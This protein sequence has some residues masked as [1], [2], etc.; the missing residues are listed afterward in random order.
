MRNHRFT[1]ATPEVIY[2]SAYQPDAASAYPVSRRAR[3]G[4]QLP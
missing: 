2:A 1:V 4:D 3:T